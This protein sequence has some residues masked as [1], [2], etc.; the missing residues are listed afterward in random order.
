M[1]AHDPATALDKRCYEETHTWLTIM[2]NISN[3][4]MPHFEAKSIFR[5][6]LHVDSHFNIPYTVPTSDTSP[7]IRN[8]EGSKQRAYIVL[9][10]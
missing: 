10:S 2:Y 4:L 1:V 3:K 5:Y 8:A 6:F 9:H 7:G